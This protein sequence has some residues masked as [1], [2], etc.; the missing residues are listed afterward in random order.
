[1]RKRRCKFE[2]VRDGGHRRFEKMR[3][4]AKK[5]CDHRVEQSIDVIRLAPLPN[6]LEFPSPSCVHR[7]AVNFIRGIIVM[8]SADERV[9]PLRLKFAK[10]TSGLAKTAHPTVQRAKESRIIAHSN[11]FRT[12]DSI[13]RATNFSYR[14]NCWLNR[15][16]PFV[17]Q[18]PWLL[19]LCF[20]KFSFCFYRPICRAK[21]NEQT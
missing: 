19:F 9:L 18:L 2:C 14:F 20:P 7:T 12:S 13:T 1:M 4:E 8:E 15:A 11:Y 10:P 5:W 6:S 21:F 3:F 17:F 16:A